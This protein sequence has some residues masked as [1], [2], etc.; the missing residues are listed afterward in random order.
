MEDNDRDIKDLRQ[1]FESNGINS[2]IILKKNIKTEKKEKYLYLFHKDTGHI[3]SIN[4]G[5]YSDFSN[6]Y[7]DIIKYAKS[8]EL[9]T[10]KKQLNSKK[11][12]ILLKRDAGEFKSHYLGN[13]DLRNIKKTLGRSRTTNKQIIVE[14][15]AYKG[16]KSQDA[17]G[18]SGLFRD[19]SIYNINEEYCDAV[20]SALSKLPFTPDYYIILNYDIKIRSYFDMR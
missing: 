14:I 2:K 17:I 5:G 4:K 13:K 15:R 9:V 8:Y 10:R 18:T 1:K 7:E 19:S 16:K 3:I 11:D 12:N 6:K 20:I